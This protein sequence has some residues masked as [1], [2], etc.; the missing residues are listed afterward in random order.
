LQEQGQVEEAVRFLKRS[1]YL[2]QGFV[3]A[4]FALGNL[5]LGQRKYKESDKHFENAL[6]L[7]SRYRPEDILPESE[8]LTAGR[9][10]N[11]IQSMT[12]REAPV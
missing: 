2:D 4:H 12:Y 5:A 9:L 1:L 3:L 6:S 8:G 11:I 10:A 7:L